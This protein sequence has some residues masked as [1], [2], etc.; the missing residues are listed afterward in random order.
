MCMLP[1]DAQGDQAQTVIYGQWKHT[2]APKNL[3]L[4][5]LGSVMITLQMFRKFG[6]R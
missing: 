2:L 5:S 3:H 4:K 1:Y 6:Q